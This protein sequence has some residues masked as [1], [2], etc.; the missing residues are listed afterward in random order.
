MVWLRASWDRDSV[1]QRDRVRSARAERRVGHD[2]ST[3]GGAAEFRSVP[4]V[5]WSEPG[6]LPARLSEKS[7]AP[8]DRRGDASARA[9]GLFVYLG[10]PAVAG[11]D[12]RGGLG[13]GWT[14]IQ[15]GRRCT[16]INADISY[17]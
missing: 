7:A 9:R 14:C 11:E 5:Q 8:V 15:D 3:R 16:Q 17:S 13:G 1:A 6:V 4:G 12:R 10:E 2:V